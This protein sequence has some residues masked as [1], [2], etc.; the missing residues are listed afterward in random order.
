MQIIVNTLATKYA[1]EG[2]GITLLLLHGWG[3]SLHTFDALAREMPGFRIV[4]LD[5]PGFG[6]SEKPNSVW[7]VAEYALFVQAFC[8]KLRVEP[9]VLIGHSF[10]GRV[11]I[12]GA[13][14]G[15]LSPQKII[16]IA[17][18]GVAKKKTLKNILLMSFAKVG[19]LITLVPP[20]SL[21]RQTIRKK[22]YGA[23]GSDYF[24]AGSMGPTFIKVVTE[25]LLEYAK[26]IRI[27]A[28]LIWGSDDR[29]TPLLDGKKINEAIIGSALEVITG[30][31]HFVHQERPQEVAALIQSFL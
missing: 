22:L 7:G 28:L 29:S 12:K 23:I 21:Y 11:I 26:K 14:E 24:A 3:D 30:A 25:D 20:F 10:G 9:Q 27:P 17:S 6:G 18:A 8:K 5:L 2:S 15:I 4:R 19:K 31:T 16:L 13:G 1:D